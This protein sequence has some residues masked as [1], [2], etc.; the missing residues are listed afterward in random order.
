[1]DMFEAGIGISAGSVVA[2]NVGSPDR[3]EYTVIG[4]PVNEAA[5]LT[6]LAKGHPARV[7]ASRGV[8]AAAGKE[9][10]AW[11]PD[12]QVDLRGRARPTE[13]YQPPA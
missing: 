12:G 9:A 2:G 8:I 11:R 5:R 4:D 3:Y 13:I 10:S 1:S 7:L 6:D